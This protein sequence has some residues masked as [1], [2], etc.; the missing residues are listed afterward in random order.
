MNLSRATGEI[1]F[2][3]FDRVLN[4][5]SWAWLRD[6]K[7][8]RAYAWA[9]ETVWNE[10]RMTLDERLLGLKCRGYADVPE[11]I[12]YGEIPAEQQNTERVS[13]LARRWSIDFVASS[14]ILLNQEGVESGE[15]QDQ[16]QDPGANS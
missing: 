14:E 10:G 13:L 4:F 16:D 2:Y 5:H 7:V 11:P 1:Q 8:V 3:S 9:A 6:G 15:D 12:R